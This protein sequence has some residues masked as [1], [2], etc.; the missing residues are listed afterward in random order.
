[1]CCSGYAFTRS[2]TWHC[3]SRRCRPYFPFAPYV[4]FFAKWNT[5]CGVSLLTHG[6]TL[7]GRGAQ[8]LEA[9]LAWHP[10]YGPWTYQDCPRYPPCVG[11]LKCIVLCTIVHVGTGP[12]RPFGFCLVVVC[13]LP[14]FPRRLLLPFDVACPSLVF[15]PLLR[16]PVWLYFM[17]KDPHLGSQVAAALLHHYI[18]LRFRMS[19]AAAQTMQVHHPLPSPPQRDEE[20]QVVSGLSGMKKTRWR[21]C[22]SPEVDDTTLSSLKKS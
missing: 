22:S 14:V 7:P 16:R 1:M 3:H 13:G 4:F 15:P 6:T 12:G 19:E 18:R 21:L 11:F 5:A 8:H 2:A 17:E 9:T 10:L 20:A